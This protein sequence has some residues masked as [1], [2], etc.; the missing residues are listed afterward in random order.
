MH[1]RPLVSLALLSSLLICATAGSKTLTVCAASATSGC[2]FSGNRG[3]QAAVDK[4]VD[5][6]IVRIRAGV[7]K[8]EHFADVPYKKYSIRGAIVI[9]NKRISIE[10]EQ[11]TII[12]GA[13]S[14]PLS[15]IVV[16]G[17]SVVFKNL[18]LR[19]LQAGDPED[20]LYEGHGIF[21][22]DANAALEDVTIEKF[23]KMALTGRGSASLLA[24]RLRIQDG[25]VAIWL[26]ESAHLK[27]CNAVVRNNDSAGIAAYLNS[28]AN[29]YNS[30][31]DG[32]QDDG[33]Y[34]ENDAR[35]F[36]TNSLVLNNK[37]FGIRVVGDARA[38]ARHTVLFGNEAKMSSPENKSQVFLGEGVSE[39]DPKADNRYTLA[40]PRDGDPDVRT[41]TLRPSQVGL[42]EVAACEVTF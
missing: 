9:Q 10:G 34:A 6:D 37:P 36:V 19:N 29:I 22:I 38:D 30:V 21:V 31:F 28:S 27:L 4:A 16:N 35:L 23:A 24:S 11:G 25:H 2:D 18:T 20:D 32:N 8:P 15:G 14:P 42:A 39:A 7:Y 40:F 13:G 12:D 33:L 17:G 26:E 5:G 1:K 3:I 41:P